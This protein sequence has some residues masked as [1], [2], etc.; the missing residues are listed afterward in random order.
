MALLIR[1]IQQN[2]ITE[3]IQPNFKPLGNNF[4]DNENSLI[5]FRAANFSLRIIRYSNQ[6]P[7]SHPSCLQNEQS[8]FSSSDDADD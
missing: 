1:I 8:L 4:L 5:W 3:I 2:K 7:V 6:S